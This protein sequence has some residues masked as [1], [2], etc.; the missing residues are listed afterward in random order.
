MSRSAKKGRLPEDR[1]RPRRQNRASK[2][3]ASA[4]DMPDPGSPSPAR[5]AGR[6]VYAPWLIC[7]LLL[8]AVAVLFGPAVQYDFVNYDDNIAVYENPAIRHGLDADGIHWALTTRHWGLWGP[9]TWLSYL[10]DYEIYGLKPWGYHLTNVVLHAATAVLLFLVL[11]R[12]TGQ[13]WPCAFVA[14]VFAIHPLHVE[15]V[16]WVSE[17]KGVLSG[18]FFVLSLG[19]YLE[20]VRRPF[21]FWRYSTVAVFFAL[22][23]M[24]K[25]ILVT[26]PFVLLLLDYWPLG[27]T[28]AIPLRRLI[29]EKIPWLLL[30]AAWCFIS[31]WEEGETVIGLEKLPLSARIGNALVSYV[32]Y[33]EKTFWPTNLAVFYPHPG[34][35][36]PTWKP[37]AALLLLSAV[38]AFVLLRWRR[39][40]CLPVGWFW[41]LGMLVPAIG[42]VQI[43][44]HA[45]ADRYMYLPQIGLCFALTWGTLYVVRSWPH[46]AW[47]CGTAASLALVALF[48]CAQQQTTYWRDGKALWT[49]AI[50]ATPQSVLAHSNLGMALMQQGEFDEAIKRFEEALRI[51]PK[52]ED[53]QCGLGVTLVRLGRLDE[54]LPHLE[55]A[56]KLWPESPGF[57]SNLGRALTSRAN[58][59]AQRGNVDGAIKDLDRAAEL[60]PS[61]AATHFNLGRAF[62]MQGRTDQAI[63]QY[64]R[65]LALAKEQH[66][67]S[68]AKSAMERIRFLQAEIP[69]QK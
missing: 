29:A 50:D 58:L 43:S 14:A 55:E 23:L 46:R 30:T 61:K 42:L 5:T 49:H 66:N 8:L 54:A 41:Y 38:T 9:V 2:P 31:P 51:D 25:P 17:R 37:L 68:L 13:L 53:A 24:S 48:A 19:A 65:A 26:L 7:S 11:W 20:Y 12:M 45:M 15:V 69:G 32:A 10:T 33:L 39:N 16:A 56:V 52:C 63:T 18:L 22:S 57:K 59:S 28:A 35:S 1:N 60:E 4:R 34:T 3:P 6:N 40:P 67:E 47:A 21:S 64:G 62:E 27:R 36:L 44:S